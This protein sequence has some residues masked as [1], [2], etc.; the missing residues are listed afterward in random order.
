MSNQNSVSFLKSVS[1]VIYRTR[2]HFREIN[3]D[4]ALSDE[5]KKRLKQFYLEHFVAPRASALLKKYF[6]ADFDEDTKAPDRQ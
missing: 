4:R 3:Y 1:S 2:M 5:D 6:P